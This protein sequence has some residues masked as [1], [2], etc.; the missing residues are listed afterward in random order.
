M[1]P[2]ASG[3]RTFAEVSVEHHPLFVEAY[4]LRA[5]DIAYCPAAICA[6]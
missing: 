6:D 1:I 2:D 3:G 5:A 4:L